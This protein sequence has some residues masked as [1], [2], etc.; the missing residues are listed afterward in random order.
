[1]VFRFIFQSMIWLPPVYMLVKK[2]SEVKMRFSLKS[3]KAVFL[4]MTYEVKQHFRDIMIPEPCL[5]HKNWLLTDDLNSKNILG[6]GWALVGPGPKKQSFLTKNIFF[7]KQSVVWQNGFEVKTT[8]LSRTK[9]GR[10]QLIKEW[11]NLENRNLKEKNGPGPGP[12][13]IFF[14]KFHF[15][16][17][18]W[19]FNKLSPNGFAPA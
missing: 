19:F 2:K 1:M 12:G 7:Q 11:R 10:N 6:P 16:Q 15:L 3:S 13:P 17:P 9:P 18:V 5:Y 14:F 4:C 8:R